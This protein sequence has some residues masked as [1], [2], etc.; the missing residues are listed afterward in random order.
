[1]PADTPVCGRSGGQRESD[2]ADEGDRPI[3]PKGVAEGRLVLR[4]D[5]LV[6]FEACLPGTLEPGHV[7]VQVRAMRPDG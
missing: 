7:S 2:V 6:I 5:R 1:M 3:T 4:Y